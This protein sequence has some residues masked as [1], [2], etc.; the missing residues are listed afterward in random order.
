MIEKGMNVDVDRLENMY[1]V[2]PYNET[3]KFKLKPLV[4]DDTVIVDKKS[5]VCY[6]KTS[7]IE[8]LKSYTIN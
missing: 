4:S 3:N 6:I 7:L 2:N 5:A 8:L 1:F